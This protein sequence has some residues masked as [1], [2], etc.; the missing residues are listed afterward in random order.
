MFPL[1]YLRLQKEEEA[2]YASIQ[3]AQSQ[4]PSQPQAQPQASLA[5]F[6]KFEER[7]TNEKTR[8]VTTVKKFFSPSSRTAPKKGD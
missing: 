7:K 3:G 4:P 1:V 2:A 6:S 5:P 8:K